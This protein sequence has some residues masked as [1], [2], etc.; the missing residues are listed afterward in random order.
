MND[1]SDLEVPIDSNRLLLENVPESCSNEMIQ[2]YLTLLLNYNLDDQ[3]KVEE[4]RRNRHRVM[5]KLNRSINYEEISER[6][7]KLP[8]LCSSQI[9]VHRVR[10][11]DTLRLSDLALNCSKEI[12]NL[13]FT[14]TKISQGG[15]IKSIKLFSYEC[16]ALIQFVDYRKVEEVMGKTHIVCDKLI[17]IEKYYGPIEDEYFLEEEEFES[18]QQEQTQQNTS[19]VKRDPIFETSREKSKRL[20]ALTSLK[21]FNTPHASIDKTKLVLANIQENT[22]IQQIDFLVQLI[23][24]KQEINEINWSLEHKGKLLIDFKQEIDINKVFL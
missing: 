13:Y 11:P 18:Q 21:S 2:L 9:T 7:K 8:Q 3:I 6:Q 24:G 22:S 1:K 20:Q 12:L 10:V 16:K 5:I 15:D 14:N 23:T 4:I 17:R 19:S